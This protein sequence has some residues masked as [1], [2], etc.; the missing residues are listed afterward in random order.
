MKTNNTIIENITFSTSIT[1]I[2]NKVFYNA[3]ANNERISAS[4]FLPV[5]NNSKDETKKASEWFSSYK[6]HFID[7][8]P[9]FEKYFNAYYSGNKSTVTSIENKLVETLHKPFHL[10]GIDLSTPCLQY[11]IKQVNACLHSIKSVTD[12]DNVKHTAFTVGRLTDS[13][14]RSTVEKALYNVITNGE[15]IDT[16]AY[17]NNIYHNKDIASLVKK[18]EKLAENGK[19]KALNNHLDKLKTLVNDNTVYTTLEKDINSKLVVIEKPTSEKPLESV[20]KSA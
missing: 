14:I 6:S 9:L 20:E 13:R 16:T 3:I 17:I 1:S 8:V 15:Y 12:I 4:H 11:I 19:T 18:C 10:L 2:D 7:S 5:G